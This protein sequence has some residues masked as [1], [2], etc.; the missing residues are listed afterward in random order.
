MNNGKVIFIVHDVYQE[1]NV[2]PIGIGY[3][4]AVLKK[5]GAGIKICCQDLFH[6][7][8]EEMATKFLKNEEYDLI[9][10]GFMAA[11]FKETIVDL[12][13]TVNKYKKNAKLILGGHG[14]SSIPEYMLKTTKADLVAIGE[15]EET[16]V[17]V[18]DAILNNRDF[19]EIKG[20]VYRD[21]N[22]IHVNERRPP[23]KDLDSIPFPAWN[24][25]PM[26]IYTTNMKYMR[27]DADEKL[28]QIITSR[29]CVNKCTFCYRMEKGI[30]FRSMKNVIDEIKSLKEKYGVTYF[31]MQDELFVASFKRLREFTD[32]LKKEKIKIKYYC[33]GIR[34]N[35]VTEEMLSLLEDSG[36]C[37]INVGFES[38][39]QKSLDE[40]KKKITVEDNFRAAELI[41]KFDIAI[42]INFIWG[43]WSDNKQTLRDTVDFIKKYNTYDELRTIRPITP[44]PGCELYYDAISKGLL[45]G[46]DDFFEKFR[47]SDLITVN[48]TEIPDD[49]FYKMLFEANKD[50]ILDHYKNNNK[51]MDEANEMINN[52][53]NLYFKG[54][55]KFRGARHLA[56]ED[57]IDIEQTPV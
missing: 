34:A 2:F 15:A 19:K 14:P 53:Y 46:P 33:G 29:G 7:T 43:I 36:C 11:R 27:Q 49:K 51:D 54:F 4:A 18:L 21:G 22:D 20:I 17:E 26:E 24:L 42:G 35:T 30:R 45:S 8:N 52:F 41:K 1:D 25:F 48:L 40:L 13:K 9:G 5:Y 28:F 38:V 44:Y 56:R 12:C 16:I 10:I 32:A 55:V 6:Y 31:V 47:N 50:L 23:I 37:Y 39:T 57:N 3:L